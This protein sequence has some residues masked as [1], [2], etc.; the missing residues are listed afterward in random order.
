VSLSVCLCVCVCVCSLFDMGGEYYCYV[1]DITCS[2]PVNGK[3]TP[4]QKLIYEAVLAAN[5]AVMNASKPGLVCDLV[6]CDLVS[7]LCGGRCPVYHH[8]IFQ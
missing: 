5:R 7:L 4:Q 1:S 3:F 6:S 8:D 2:F